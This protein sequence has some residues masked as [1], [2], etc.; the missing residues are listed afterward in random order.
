MQLSLEFHLESTNLCHGGNDRLAA[1]ARRSLQLN[2][3]QRS[4]CVEVSEQ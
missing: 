2:S 3:S 1:S 4:M